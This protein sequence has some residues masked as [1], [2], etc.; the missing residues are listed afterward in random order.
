MNQNLQIAI[1]LTIFFSFRTLTCVR[2][3]H[4]INMQPKVGI[5]MGSSTISQSSI[6]FCRVT[7]NPH[8]GDVPFSLS[9]NEQLQRYTFSQKTPQSPTPFPLGFSFSLSISHFITLNLNITTNFK[10]TQEDNDSS[11]RHYSIQ[12]RDVLRTQRRIKQTQ[13]H[14]KQKERA[15]YK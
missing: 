5:F 9:I 14:K 7:E 10:S 4:F 8:P 1:T 3:Y 15:K 6:K 12:T 2:N 11:T 13:T